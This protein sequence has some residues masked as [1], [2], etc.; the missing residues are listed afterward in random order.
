MPETNL[1]RIRLLD[2]KGMDVE[3]TAL[4]K[5]FGASLSEDAI[6][7]WLKHNAV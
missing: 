7:A 6:R 2:E 1:I 3:K 5:A 4:G